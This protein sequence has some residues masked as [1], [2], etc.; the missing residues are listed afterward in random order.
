MRTILT[1]QEQDSVPVIHI[2]VFQIIKAEL[3]TMIILHQY[4]KKKERKDL[5]YDFTDIIE[6]K[7]EH[8]FKKGHKLAYN[9][10]PLMFN[11]E[12]IERLHNF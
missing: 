6:L 8:K 2:N 3:T 9:L 5:Y 1:R 4:K 10:H 7:L 11:S 12:R